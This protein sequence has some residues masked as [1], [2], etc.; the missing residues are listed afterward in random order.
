MLSHRTPKALII[1]R[2]G[3]ALIHADKDFNRSLSKQ[4][5][6]EVTIQAKSIY[7]WLQELQNKHEQT[8]FGHVLISSSRRTQESYLQVLKVWETLDQELNQSFVKNCHFVSLDSLYLAPASTLINHVLEVSMNQEEKPSFLMFIGHNPGL[9]DL[10]H[11]LSGRW[12]SLKT[13]EVK[14]LLPM[15]EMNKWTLA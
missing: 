4:G 13:A 15:G 5:K 14:Y 12:L 2:H 11:E 6:T 8:L 10:I 7:L 3:E 9:S 1:L